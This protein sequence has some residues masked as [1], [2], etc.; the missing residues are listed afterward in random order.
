MTKHAQGGRGPGPRHVKVWAC[1]LACYTESFKPAAA[2]VEG[3]YAV[4]AVP[5]VRGSRLQPGSSTPTSTPSVDKADSFGAQAWQAASLFQQ[6]VNQVVDADGPNGITRAS[7]PRGAGRDRGLRRR[8]LDGGEGP[9]GRL[10][11]LHGASCRSRTAS[12]PGPPRP[13]AGT[14]D[15][16]TSNLDRPFDP[17]SRRPRPRSSSVDIQQGTGGSGP[18]RSPPPDHPH[19]SAPRGEHGAQGQAQAVSAVIVAAAGVLRRSSPTGA[20]TR[21]T[22][23]TSPRSSSSASRSAAST[24]SSPAASSSP[25]PP[26]ASSTSPMLRSG[27]SWPSPTGS[28]R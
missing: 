8:R 24:P 9:E 13:R 19:P 21:S 12:S 3:T 4:D 11:G 18:C 28:A 5:A 25:T 1:S 20:S 7:A 2:D 17:R 27:A 26:P 10:L 6:A 23:R 16:D 15:C 14:L 22:P